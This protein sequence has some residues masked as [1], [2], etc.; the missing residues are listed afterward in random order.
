MNLYAE[1]Y[2]EVG[3]V[4]ITNEGWMKN[5]YILSV[6]NY[7]KNIFIKYVLHLEKA[8]LLRNNIRLRRSG[9]RRGR[10]PLIHQFGEV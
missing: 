5:K 3:G 2:N 10:N 1:D 7:M 6:L 9:G 4:I 8:G